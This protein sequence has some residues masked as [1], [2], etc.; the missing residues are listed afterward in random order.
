MNRAWAA[1]A[2]ALGALAIGIGGCGG[3]GPV[4]PGIAYVTGRAGTVPEVWLASLGGGRGNRLGNGTQPLLSP[5]GAFVAASAAASSGAALVLYSASGS[6]V[7]RYFDLGNATAAAQAWSPD[8][9]YLAVAL[10]SSD[11][12]SDAASGLAVIDTRSYTYKI[13][14]R[15]Q[16]YGASFAPD[17]SSRLVYASASSTALSAPVNVHVVSADGKASAQLTHNGRSLN[18]VWGRTAIAFDREQ[19]RTTAEPA[20]EVWTMSPRGTGARQ[21][22]H[23]PTPPLREGPV[24][25]GF[26][27][28]GARLLAQYEGQDTSEAWLIIP[29]SGRARRL[30]IGGQAVTGAGISRNG[31]AAL[32]DLGG[33]LNPP[34]AGTVQS[35]ALAD[36]HPRVLIAHGSQP[37]WNL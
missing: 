2:V 10:S 15:G 36:G 37:S 6:A 31:T 34:D 13:V 24:P 32:V 18:P 7:H 8:S 9:R 1:A 26:S 35:L 25:I 11:P 21:V 4:R 12:S 23:L 16:I 30:E 5:N 22:T 20:Y 27:G 19:I 29:A 14:A 3:S 28:D 17:R 33:Y